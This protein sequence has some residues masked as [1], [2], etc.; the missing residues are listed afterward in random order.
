MRDSKHMQ[1]GGVQREREGESQ[2]DCLLSV[3]PGTGLDPM[4]L[5]YGLSQMILS[6]A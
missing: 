4:A 6:D 3:D 5:R 2:A 1:G